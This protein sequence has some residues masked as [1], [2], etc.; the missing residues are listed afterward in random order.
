MRN[1][2][3][4]NV[5]LAVVAFS[6]LS[7]LQAEGEV[8]IEITNTTCCHRILVGHGSDLSNYREYALGDKDNSVKIQVNMKED[9]LVIPKL[10]QQ[11]NREVH[12]WKRFSK[13]FKNEESPDRG[14][15]RDGN[16]YVPLQALNIE[17]KFFRLGKFAKFPGV[18]MVNYELCP[19]R[20]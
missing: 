12:T 14:W 6:L 11:L 16:Y 20:K 3:L 8:E 13:F 15:L 19:I 1:N 18:L 17:D 9:V 4:F 5:G 2:F 10:Q 7:P